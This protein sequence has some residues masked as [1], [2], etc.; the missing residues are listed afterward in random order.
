MR[1]LSASRF[2][3]IYNHSFSYVCQWNCYVP[4]FSNSQ[5]EFVW[6]MLSANVPR[7]SNSQ[8]AFVW[9]MQAQS[10]QMFTQMN[11]VTRT[12]ARIVGWVVQPGRNLH[13]C[14]HS[15]R[16]EFVFVGLLLSPTLLI[17]L[18]NSIVFLILVVALIVVC[19]LTPQFRL[20]SGQFSVVARLVF[21]G[22]FFPYRLFLG[23]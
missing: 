18:D 20:V 4:L 5:L 22:L 6:T 21:L 11:A 9:T 19:S 15:Q 13:M 3:P 16:G 10:R 23:A 14:P 12:Q 17:V 8:L 1:C 2:T 7:F